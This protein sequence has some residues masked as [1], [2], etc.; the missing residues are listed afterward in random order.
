MKDGCDKVRIS[1]RWECGSAENMREEM[2]RTLTSVRR[3]T[4]REWDR[5]I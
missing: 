4:V 3:I 1:M 5:S 2:F